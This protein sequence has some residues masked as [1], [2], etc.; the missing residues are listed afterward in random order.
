MTLSDRERRLLADMARR[1]EEQEPEL[2]SALRGAGEPAPRQA[3]W[4]WRVLVGWREK[5]RES[6]HAPLRVALAGGML[7]FGGLF[8]AAN[9]THGQTQAPGAETHLPIFAEQDLHPEPAAPSN[10]RIGP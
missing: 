3:P 6:E 9:L 8:L 5:F 7:F 1:L 2:A 4:A 10:F